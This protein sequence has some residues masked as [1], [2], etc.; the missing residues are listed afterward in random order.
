MNTDQFDLTTL[1]TSQM[2]PQI[3]KLRSTGTII[4]VVGLVLTGLSVAMGASAQGFWSRFWASYLMS[5][6]FWLGI[7]VGSL[8]LLLVHN[9]VGGGWGFVLRRFLEAASRLLPV[10]AVLYIP[11]IIGYPQIYAWARPDEVAHDK[12]LQGQTWWMTPAFVIA[13]VVI[14]FASWIAISTI[15]NSRYAKLDEKDDPEITSWLSVFSAPC[16]VWY[17]ITVTVLSIDWVMT[18]TPH[19]VSSI[20]GFLYVVGQGLSTWALMAILATEVTKGEGVGER[21]PDRYFRDI[22]NF[23]LAFTLL[24]AYMSFSQYVITYSGNTAEEATWYVER[25]HNGWPIIGFGLIAFHFFA[26]F[27]TLM[28]STVK[29]RLR[30]LAKLGAFIIFMR[31]VDLFWWTAPHFRPGLTIS[32]MDIGLPLAM[33]GLWLVLWTMQLKD[34]TLVAKYDP[35]F[36]LYWPPHGHHGHAEAVGHGGHEVPA[37][38]GAQAAA[39]H[40]RGD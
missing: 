8:A 15:I 25:S 27:F 26:P 17:V 13:R 28:S 12:V 18:L 40:G 36:R 24:W 22:G 7:T 38:A 5:Y 20:I 23:T 1:N 29:V 10:M 11:I 2:A 4:A 31:F 33:G 30:N 37:L 35:R 14:M 21:I 16:I 6:V 9:V 3:A 19:W 32:P 34:K 39:A